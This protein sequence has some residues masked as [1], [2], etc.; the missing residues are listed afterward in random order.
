MLRRFLLIS[1]FMLFLPFA[2]RPAGAAALP[3]ESFSYRADFETTD[4]V[5][6][7]VGSKDYT[8]NFKGLTDEKCVEGKKCLK[9]DVTLGGGLPYVYWYIPMPKPVPAEDSLKFTGRAYLGAETTANRV[10]IGPSFSCPPST[11]GGTCPFMY[12]V[13]AKAKEMWLPVQGDLVKIAGVV[14]VSNYDWGDPTLANTGMY[15]DFIIVRF[16]GNKGDRIVLY[17]DDFKVEGQVPVAAEYSK[18]I[19]ARWAPIKEKV[20]AKAAE[21]ESALTRNAQ[22]I[23]SITPKTADGEKLKKDMLQKISTLQARVKDIKAKGTMRIK[24]MQDIESS[25]KAIE[26]SKGNL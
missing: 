20:N 22:G 25:I 23:S 24:D 21:F 9:M 4:P 18:E 8:V 17:L 5:K 7:W 12:R 6:Y 10:E 13:D 3:M 11:V 15:L 1:A 14:N 16:F 19:P 2:S 26:E